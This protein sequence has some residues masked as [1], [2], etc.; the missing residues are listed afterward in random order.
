MAAEGCPPRG[1]TCSTDTSVSITII[2]KLNSNIIHKLGP[3]V[4][5][6]GKYLNTVW[7]VN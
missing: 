2:R 4:R 1:L 3:R 7:L 5:A 6:G